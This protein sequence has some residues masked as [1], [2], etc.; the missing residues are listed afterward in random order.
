MA[1]AADRKRPIKPSLP[2][3]ERAPGLADRGIRWRRTIDRDRGRKQK[4]PGEGP[5]HF[6]LSK[7]DGEAQRDS[8]MNPVPFPVYEPRPLSEIVSELPGSSK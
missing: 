7:R 1:A 8:T 3:F 5:G 2:R 6:L 4:W